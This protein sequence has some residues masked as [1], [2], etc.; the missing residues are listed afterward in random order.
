MKL[1]I[2]SLVLSL[3]LAATLLAACGKESTES[4]ESATEPAT[5]ATVDEPFSF[6]EDADAL[7]GSWTVTADNMSMNFFFNGSGRGTASSLGRNMKMAY[8]IHDDEVIV[9]LYYPETEETAT[10]VF[11]Y[12]VNGDELTLT[13][14]DGL[15]QVFTRDP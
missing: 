1:K 15:V 8:E 6:P 3:I 13:T 5:A 14:S 4:T 2:I 11:T 7:A 9:V 10:F 12:E